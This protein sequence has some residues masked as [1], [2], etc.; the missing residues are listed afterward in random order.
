MANNKPPVVYSADRYKAVSLTL[1]CFVVYSMRIFVLCVTTCYSVLVFFNSFSIAVTSLG[2]ERA[3][4]SAFCA[5]VRF[6]LVWFCR[7]PLPLGAWEG[8]RFVIVALPGL[9]FIFF[10]D[11]KVRKLRKE[12][13]EIVFS[14]RSTFCWCAVV[15]PE[16]TR[17]YLF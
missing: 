1:C 6:V 14:C 16:R 4:F 5:F 9:L 2:E 10:F 13:T 17:V 15:N 8:L 11:W 12:I 3:N 7:F